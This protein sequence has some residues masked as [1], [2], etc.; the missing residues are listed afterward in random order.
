[1]KTLPLTTRFWRIHFD[2]AA[3]KYGP[4]LFKLV[5]SEAGYMS[6]FHASI[7]TRMKYRRLK[8]ILKAAAFS[9]IK[10]FQMIFNEKKH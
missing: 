10:V 8:D 3:R 6:A 2:V 9:K 5:H 1:M 7:L 4:C